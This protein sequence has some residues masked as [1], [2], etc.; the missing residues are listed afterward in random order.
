MVAA[1]TGNVKVPLTFLTLSVLL[2][3]RPQIGFFYSLFSISLL[4]VGGRKERWHREFVMYLQD[5]KSKES[6][7]HQWGSL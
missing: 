1:S 7:L 6:R 5:P 3:S 4:C 2:H